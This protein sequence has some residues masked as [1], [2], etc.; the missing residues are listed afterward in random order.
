MMKNR[1]FF[2]GIP[3]LI[4]VFGLMMSACPND[5]GSDGDPAPA[6]PPAGQG[7]LTIYNDSDRDLEV[8]MVGPSPKTDV[9][10]G[11]SPTAAY[12]T[13]TKALDTGTYNVTVT[14]TSGTTAARPVTVPSSGKA[15]VYSAAGGVAG[16]LADV[17]PGNLPTAGTKSV[18]LKNTSSNTRIVKVKIDL[19]QAGA[20]DL[21]ETRYKSLGPGGEDTWQL[22]EVE[23]TITLWYLDSA[24]GYQTNNKQITPLG[25]GSITWSGVSLA[26]SNVEVAP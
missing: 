6:G 8:T 7:N 13:F 18:T 3:G 22:T 21:T 9:I 19:P 24:N 23:H 16:A 15:Q 20:A 2:K 25:D 4:L 12:G 11:G 26:G 5:S 10:S 17:V 14:T 1:W